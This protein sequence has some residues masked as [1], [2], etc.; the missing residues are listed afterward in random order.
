M[1]IGV[2]RCVHLV[3]ESEERMP[4]AIMKRPLLGSAGAID[5]LVRPA[6]PD[7]IS[8]WWS[9]SKVKKDEIGKIGSAVRKGQRNEVGGVLRS[10]V[11]RNENLVTERVD[12]GDQGATCEAFV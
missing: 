7:G 5:M 11:S 6:G 1:G 2:C 9:T 3:P 8:K 10:T 4:A 12:E